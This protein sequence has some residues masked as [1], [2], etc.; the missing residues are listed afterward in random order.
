M[1]TK[2]KV[3]T[4]TATKKAAATAP[5]VNP[6]KIKSD[7]LSLA[8]ALL[9]TETPTATGDTSAM[10]GA[11]A[12]EAEPPPGVGSG[13]DLSAGQ[14]VKD[15]YRLVVDKIRRRMGVA[16]PIS[17]AKLTNA[18]RAGAAAIEEQ[19]VS[20]DPRLQRLVARR[21]R[22]LMEAATASTAQD[23]V[24]VIARV[25]STEKWEA[26]SEVV[27]GGTMGDKAADGSYLV[28]GRIPVTRIPKVRQKD[29]VLSLKAAQPLQPALFATTEETGARPDLL[30]G[31]HQTNGGEGVV[32]GVID[33]GGDFL[34]ENFRNGDGSTRLI[35]LWHQGGQV[36]SNSPFN[37]G[38]EYLADEINA[39]LRQANPYTALGYNPGFNSHGTHVMDIAAG[40]GNGSGTAGVAPKADLIFVDV[41]H[42][43]IP[44]T[45][46]H[47]VDSSFGD[48]TR[49]LEAIKYI[50]EKAGDRPCV[51]NVSL[52][53]N[54]GPHDGSTLVEDGIDRLLNQ[55]DNR[56]V[57]IAASN[58]YDDGIHAQG[59]VREGRHKDLGWQIQAGDFS[60]NEFELW[61]SGSDRISVELI[62]PAGESLG[63]VEPGD[64]LPLSLDGD[65]VVFVANRLNDP[66][67][68]DNMIGIFLESGLPTGT[69]TVRLHGT[70]IEDGS[71][72]AWIERD[73]TT[74]SSF[75]PPNNNTHTIGSISCGQKSI[76]VGSYDA[77]KPSLP[78]SF[79]SSSGPTR[80]QREKPEI[81]A[82]GHAVWAADSRSITGTTRKSG[83]SMAAPAVA[84]IAALVFAEATANGYSLSVD[85]IRQILIGSTRRNPPT[86]TRWHAR[87]GHGR[88]SAKQ[89]VASVMPAAGSG[90]G[91]AAA[92]A[93]SPSKKR[94]RPKKKSAP[95]RR[96]AAKKRS[97]KK[98]R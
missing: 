4:K 75:A 74:Q 43:D 58:S 16:N 17:S 41:S 69:W 98:R 94:K 18:L 44:F 37:Y 27:I 86:G 95:K 81:S 55:A 77:H 12:P 8:K 80:D 3:S 62:T 90:S 47:V 56:A 60:H 10:L 26:L 63:I 61:Y 40:N 96:T 88:I 57:I 30:P 29:F 34:H 9:S 73:N 91:S 25:A 35:S 70:S 51:I 97:A 13:P 83:T 46:H 72:H 79:F 38:R 23:E 21:S 28:T 31:G 53:T 24:A 49:L 67:N 14:V 11:V 54:G 39:A 93:S 85:D 78:L 20:M 68:N 7:I 6:A 52:G 87:Y 89:A 71:F 32:V 19:V 45:G 42:A 1:P 5:A 36:S 48:S 22:G 59:T 82:P 65:V 33:Y 76:V 64:T 2:T 84:G 15:T 92:A 50:F 66:N